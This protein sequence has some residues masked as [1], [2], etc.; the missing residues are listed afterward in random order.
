MNSAKLLVL[1][2]ARSGSKRLPGKNVRT[3]GGIPM[4]EWTARAAHAAGIDAPLILSTESSAIATVGVNCGFTVPFIRPA[5]LAAHDMPMAAV[6][7]HAMDWY[8]VE[9]GYDPELVMLLQITSPFR[10]PA[11]IVDGMAAC[12][13]GGDV[14]AA[15][16]MKPLPVGA[17]HVYRSDGCYAAPIGAA[18]DTARVYVP[19]GA[20][21][22][23]R[24]EVLRHRRS[25]APARTILLKHDGISALD[26]DTPDDW[27]LAEA[28]VACG[29]AAPAPAS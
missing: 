4:M 20:L 11:L 6:V 8:A 1:A 21:Y 7:L 18:D 22:L 9:H 23:T 5:A 3:L 14:N 24:A 28:A 10:P 13:G 26:I 29:L 27:A 12:A 15:V 16:A 17:A 25:F 19:T 2:P